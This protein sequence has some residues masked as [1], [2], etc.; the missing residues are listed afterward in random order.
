[1]VFSDEGGKTG[2]KCKFISFTERLQNKMF[3]AGGCKSS[4]FLFDKRE[5]SAR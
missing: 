2:Q 1:M 3:F 5:G 4:G